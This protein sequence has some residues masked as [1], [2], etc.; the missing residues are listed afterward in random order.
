MKSMK[1]L[2]VSLLLCLG[3]AYSLS[4]AR[5]RKSGDTD[6]ETRIEKM[7]NDT[8]YTI[9]VSSALPMGGRTVMLNSYYSLEMAKDTVRSYL[10]YFGRAYSIPYGGGKGLVFDGTAENYVV[11]D[12]KKGGNEIEFTVRNE[13]DSYTYNLSIYPNG[14]AYISV[15]GN[16]RQPI[17]YIGRIDLYGK[18][19]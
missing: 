6:D 16:K 14:S 13:E 8:T 5:D 3:V 15:R 4:N 11:K 7:I 17:S 2:F 18:E 1:C 19:D 12:G 10:P 9:N